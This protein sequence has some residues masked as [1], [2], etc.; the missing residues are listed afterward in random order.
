MYKIE[1]LLLIYLSRIR[2]FNIRIRWKGKVE[3]SYGIKS[4]SRINTLVF[5]SF[6]F[7]SRKTFI[8]C[9]IPAIYISLYFLVAHST[10]QYNNTH[11][12]DN[13]INGMFVCTYPLSWRKHKH[14]Y[15]AIEEMI[16]MACLN[17]KVYLKDFVDETTFTN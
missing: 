3:I 7:K 11:N 4:K 8:Y 2:L 12:D 6:Y 14:V 10:K 1:T 5:H 13:H 16:N 15:G 17:M 9:F